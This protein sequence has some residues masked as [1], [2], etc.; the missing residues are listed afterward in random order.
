MSAPV[1][2][3]VVLGLSV[4]SSW[5]NGH[6]TTYRGLMRELAA[7]KHSVLFLERDMPWYA[8]HRDLPSP[9]YGLTKIYSSVDELKS[10]YSEAIRTAD[11][12]IVGSFVPDGI[13]IGEWV[14]HIAEGVS[15]FYDIDTPVTIARL[16][17]A[18]CDY[19]STAL[20]PRYDLYLSFTGGPI[21][22]ELQDSFGAAM[23]RPLYCSADT[24]CYYPDETVPAYDLGYMGTHSDDRQPS[25]DL[26]LLEPARRWK[27]GKFIIAGPQYPDIKL[28]PRN[29]EFF[30][31]LNPAQHR[32]FYSSQRFT[33]NLTRA[34]MIRAGYS[35]SVRLFEA[36]ACGTPIISDYWEG[37]ETFFIL[38]E[39]ILISRSAEETLRYLTGLP[40]EKRRSL[41]EKA[42]IRFLS[43]HTAAHRVEELERYT[44]E[45]FAAHAKRRCAG[46]TLETQLCNPQTSTERKI[47][48][49]GPWFHNLHLPDGCQTA[50]QHPLG[51]FPRFL[52]QAVAP[53]IPAD[54]TDWNVLDIGCNAGF[55]CFELARRGARCT[56]IDLDDHYLRQARW[57]AHKYGLEKSTTFLQGHVYNLAYTKKVYDLVLFMGL[58]Y[59]LRHP[60]LALDII[61]QKVKTMMIFQTLTMPGDKVYV[62]EKDLVFNERDKMHDTGWPK[63]A[64]IEQSLAGDPTNWWAPNHAAVE[65]ILRSSGFHVKRIASEVYLCI[66]AFVPR[67]NKSPRVDTFARQ[68]KTCTDPSTFVEAQ[69]ESRFA[70]GLVRLFDEEI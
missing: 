35:P 23:V 34:D 15:A 42:R 53:H 60:L 9:P 63:M 57:A 40:E 58:F 39:E 44:L 8:A 1:F 22:R 20:V 19:L 30:D 54:L 17:S 25:L 43:S 31:H 47:A 11:L 24:S 18:R 62:P 16:K 36:A 13:V 45:A 61:A 41:G 10:S 3:I 5:G 27:M 6:A 56:G 46:V 14:T 38:G 37:L 59:H 66:P 51:D 4:T 32:A 21:V 2:D 28:W 33:L 29:V 12:V 49:L 68:P 55:Y 50:P 26:L 65:A 48:E 64:F 67:S 7:R 70:T 52:W 69:R